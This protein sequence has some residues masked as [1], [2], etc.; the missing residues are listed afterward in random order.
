MKCCVAPPPA[1][2]HDGECVVLRLLTVGCTEATYA[3]VVRVW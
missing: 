2:V 3:Q 1:G